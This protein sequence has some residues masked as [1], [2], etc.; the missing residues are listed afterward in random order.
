MAEFAPGIIGC[1]LPVHGL[2]T[3]TTTSCQR[4]SWWLSA[5]MSGILRERHCRE[6]AEGSASAMLS[7]DPCLG[8]WWTSRRG[9]VPGPCPRG[10]VRASPRS[11]DGC[12]PAAGTP[13]RPCRS[14][15][16]SHRRCGPRHPGRLPSRRRI[17]RFW[18]VGL[19]STPSDE[20]EV[21]FLQLG[22]WSSCPAAEA[23]R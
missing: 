16:R 15:G 19:P 7:H 23:P 11:P 2:L 5:S 21:S 3:A 17:P 12:I 4:P 14:P 13:S 6:S 9:P 8:L 1:E 22:R 20:A 18:W 10:R